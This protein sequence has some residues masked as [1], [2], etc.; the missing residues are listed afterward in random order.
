MGDPKKFRKKYSTPSHPWQKTAIEEEKVVKREY[1]LKNKREIMIANSFLKKY[2]DI[3]K[4]LIASKTVQ[5]AKEK[6][7]VLEK[8]Q[9][10]GILGSTSELDHILGL[11]VQDVLN[12]RLQSVIYRKGLA[13]TMDQARQFIT[14]RHIMVGENEITSP[15]YLTSLEEEI[16][17]SFKAKSALADPEHPE[18]AVVKKE[19][20][21]EAVKTEVKEEKKPE[22]KVL[23]DD[24]TGDD[25]EVAVV[26][27]EE[28]VIA[29][30]SE[31]AGAEEA[32]E[33]KE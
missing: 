23:P 10:L 16:N 31:E 9:R 13:R 2:K 19:A 21:Q 15:S 28:P 17:L 29:D 33:D 3:A 8:L 11:S 22:V 27:S 25:L 18:R 32:T 30:E 5:G 14:H 1:G 12:R 20:P 4:K 7:Q 24:D 6:Q 26:E